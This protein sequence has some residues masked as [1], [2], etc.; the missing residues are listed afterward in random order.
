[1]GTATVKYVTISEGNEETIAANIKTQ[2]E[3]LDPDPAGTDING[4]AVKGSVLYIWKY[5]P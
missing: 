3:A 5:T 1:M 2:L 4:F